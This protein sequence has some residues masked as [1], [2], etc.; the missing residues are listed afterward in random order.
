MIFVFSIDIAFRN[1]VVDAIYTLYAAL[2]SPPLPGWG[3]DVD[4]CNGKWQ[5]VV[6]E[7]TNI[8]SMYEPYSFYYCI[9][10]RVY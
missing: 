10:L 2:G 4:P 1:G 3:V 6:C 8:V 7:D 5:G 9:I